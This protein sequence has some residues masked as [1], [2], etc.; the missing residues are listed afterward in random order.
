MYAMA[1]FYLA[2]QNSAGGHDTTRPRQQGYNFNPKI[3]AKISSENYQKLI[4]KL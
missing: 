2:F 3:F 4:E 1:G